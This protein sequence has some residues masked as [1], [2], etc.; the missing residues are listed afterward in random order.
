[1]LGRGKGCPQ[2]WH[3]GRQVMDLQEISQQDSVIRQLQQLAIS[4][5]ILLAGKQQN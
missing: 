4:A 2:Q 1:M 3:E 5:P